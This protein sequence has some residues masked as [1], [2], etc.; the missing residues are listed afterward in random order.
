[1]PTAITPVPKFTNATPTR[2]APGESAGWETGPSPLLPIFQAL[3]DRA[4]YVRGITWGLLIGAD[5]FSVDGGG[6]ST[7][8]VARLNPFEAMSVQD[9]DS[10]FWPVYN[11]AETTFTEAHYAGGTLPNDS[12]IYAYL[13]IAT[14]GTTLV[15][16]LSTTAPNAS[17]TWKS[18]NLNR[19][20]FVGCFRTGTA[21]APLPGTLVRGRWVYRRSAMA[22]GNFAANGLEAVNSLVAAYTALD[23][24]ARVP[25]HARRALLFGQA[26]VTA[27][28]ATAAGALNLYDGSET[29]SIAQVIEAICANNGE[30]DQNSSTAEVE[31]DTQAV[32]YS[33]TQTAGIAAGVIRVVGWE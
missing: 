27:T 19:R 12:W 22:T 5:E 31:L 25:P 30:S 18:D 11:T 13:G 32:G 23:L 1:M 8:F 24:S 28:G 21:G 17:K 29:T 20:R 4:Q 10:V 15:K 6:S 3:F 2:P 7:S 26:N 33:I 14:D 16:E 9:T